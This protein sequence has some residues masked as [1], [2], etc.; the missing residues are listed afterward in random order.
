VRKLIP[1]LVLPLFLTAACGSGSDS[2]ES[3]TDAPAAESK[4]SA[5][6]T[7]VKSGFGQAGDYAEAIAIVKNPS[8]KGGQ[9][10]TV[11]VNALDDAGDIIATEEQVEQ[12]T[13]GGQSLVMPVFFDLSGKDAKIAS[14]EPSVSSDN[15]GDLDRAPLTDVPAQS[16]EDDEF[17][18]PLAK[19][20]IKNSTKKDF[21]DLRIGVVCTDEAGDIIGGKSE[22]PELIAAGKDALVESSPIV[23][24]KSAECTASLNYGE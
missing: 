7:I 11:S 20:V 13:W 3:K 24:G 10:V 5:A 15:D 8:T 22:Y 9:F 6:P 17:G 1:A 19:F 18:A 21:T 2:P 23:S 12:F 14:I 4:K 16:I